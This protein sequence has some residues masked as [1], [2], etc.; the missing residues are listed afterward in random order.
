MRRS[1]YPCFQE[2]SVT[3]K[4]RVPSLAVG[5]S[6]IV[7]LQ[8]VVAVAGDIALGSLTMATAGL[9]ST[10]RSCSQK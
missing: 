8:D 2:A 6:L 4:V 10:H 9:Q 1:A 5:F 7:Q 3:V